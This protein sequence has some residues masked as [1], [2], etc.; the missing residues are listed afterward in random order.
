MKKIPT[1]FLRDF[2]LKGN[3]ITREENPSC[4]W[5]FAGEGTATRKI[6]GTCCLVREGHLWKRYETKGPWPSAGILLEE[7]ANTG[8]KYGWVLVDDGPSDKYHREAFAAVESLL[9]DGTYE[10]IGPKVQ[11][12]PEGATTHQLVAHTIEE[13]GGIDPPRSYDALVSWLETQ[14]I[15]GIVWHHPDGR[16]AKIKKRDFGLKR[17]PKNLTAAD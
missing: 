15:E 16:M 1:I 3:P 9:P 6:D 10:L 8:K 7:D 12:N 17:Q 11:S 2:T 13:L 4:A 5:V 14:D